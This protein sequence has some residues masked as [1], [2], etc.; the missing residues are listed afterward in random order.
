MSTTGAQSSQNES[1]EE[2]L[3][4]YLYIGKEYPVYHPGNWLVHNYYTPNNVPS[5]SELAKN[6]DNPEIPLDLIKKLY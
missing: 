1:P 2:K 3:N 5:I 6:L 4:R